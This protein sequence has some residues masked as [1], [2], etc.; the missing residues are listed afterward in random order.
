MAIRDDHAR[1]NNSEIENTRFVVSMSWM[2]KTILMGG[3]ECE[4]NGAE[5]LTWKESSLVTQGTKVHSA[6]RKS[7]AKRS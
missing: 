3:S 1:C 5:G 6:K 2:G 4:M 7:I